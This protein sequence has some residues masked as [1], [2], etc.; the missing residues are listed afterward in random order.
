MIVVTGGAGFIGSHIV[1][2]LAAAGRRIV[3]CDLFRSGAKWRHITAVPVYDLVRPEALFEWLDR[4]RAEVAAIVHMAAISTT[5][6]PDIDRY[7]A[8]NVPL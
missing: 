5:T 8:V 3:V 4:H 7:V 6:E 2:D 1:A